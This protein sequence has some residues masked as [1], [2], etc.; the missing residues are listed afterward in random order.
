MPNSERTSPNNASI[1]DSAAA[2]DT[3]AHDTA[4]HSTAAHSGPK[5]M[6]IV[7][8]GELHAKGDNTEKISHLIKS[9]D[10]LIAA[11]AGLKHCEYFGVWPDVLIGDFDSVDAYL[12]NEA[13]KQGSKVLRFKADKDETD[14]ELAIEV[15]LRRSGRTEHQIEEPW[16]LCVLAAFGG[17]IDHT[18]ANLTVLAKPELARLNPVA[19]DGDT[20]C[21][22]VRGQRPIDVAEGATFSLIPIG[23]DA[24]QVTVTGAKWP[25]RDATLSAY[26][27]IGISNVALH[28]Q[29]TVSVGSG[30]LAVVINSKT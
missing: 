5:T 3:A 22:L 11:D 10:Y 20:E 28:T 4:A 12:Y 1:A 24:H 8:A 23:S 16:H 6:L 27:A 19:I 26:S 13:L 15:A 2:H 18:I 25:L 14:F 29:L 30:C 9:C 7:L 17:R 21:H